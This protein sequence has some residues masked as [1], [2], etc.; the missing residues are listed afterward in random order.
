MVSRL[1]RALSAAGV[2]VL[3]GSFAV[4]QPAQA[5][6]SPVKDLPRAVT[7]AGVLRHLVAFQAI[8]KLNGDPRAS[9]GQSEIAHGVAS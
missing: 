1:S 9:G 6:G 3:L 7:L 5:T 8:A 2:A 4:A